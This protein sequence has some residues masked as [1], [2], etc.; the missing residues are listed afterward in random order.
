MVK[1]KG[2]LGEDV[3]FL[4]QSELEQV[5]DDRMD[6]EA[7]RGL[8][9]NRRDAFLE[10][11]DV[12]TF[13]I[14]GRPMDEFPSNAKIIYGIGTSPGRATGRARIVENPTQHNIQRG[15]ILVAKNTDPGWTPVLRIVAG[16]IVEE[17]GILNHC[18]IVARELG[19]PAVVGVRQATQKIPENAPIT[20]DGGLGAVQMTEEDHTM[21]ANDLSG[22]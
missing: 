21:A 5:V 2:G 16:I 13:Y 1:D 11:S 9:R 8:A 3:L 4:T 17:G 14:D 12:Y 19:I 22:T 15:D 20:I 7:A 18:S 10:Q 6:F